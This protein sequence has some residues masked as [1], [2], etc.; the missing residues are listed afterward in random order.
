MDPVVALGVA[1]MSD[2]DK[3]TKWISES[4]LDPNDPT[5]AEL[6]GIMRVKLESVINVMKSYDA[7]LLQLSSGGD[8]LVPTHRMPVHF[9]LEQM[10]EEFNFATDAEMEK[11]RRFRMLQLRQQEVAEFKNKIVPAL[12]KEIPEDI[13]MVFHA[14]MNLMLLQV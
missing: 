8:G 5:N 9:H 2:M 1:G 11:S 12:E 10:Q 7:I 13:F 4:R 3:L 14:V 6:M